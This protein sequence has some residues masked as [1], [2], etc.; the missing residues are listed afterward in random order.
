MYLKYL[1]RHGLHNIVK[2]VENIDLYL[3]EFNR[4]LKPDGLLL[5]STHGTWQYHSSPIDI[6][7]WTSY[8]LKKLIEKYNFQIID[9][10]PVL[11]Q[12]AITSQL[13]LNYYYSLSNYLGILGKILLV[14]ISML[15]QIKIFFEDKI[16]PYRVKVRDSAIYIVAGLKN[17]YQFIV[18]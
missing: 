16:T 2:D 5:L 9:F 10:V 11:G 6:Q 13:R 8:G 18:I 1:I 7:R 4:L 17:K 15:Y 3:S 12:L 14:P